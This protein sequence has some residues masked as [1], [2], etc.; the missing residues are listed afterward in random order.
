VQV[1]R[2]GHNTLAKVSI[3]AVVLLTG[4][5][6]WFLGALDRSPYKTEQRVIRDQPIAFSH[7]HHVGGLGLDCR[8]CHLSVETSKFAGLPPTSVCMNCHSQIWSN[9]SALAPVRDSYKNDKS[10]EWVRVHDL[11]DFAYF[12]HSIHVAKGVGCSTC[13]G[14]VDQMPLM[15]KEKTLQMEWCLECHRNP[16]RFVRPLKQVFQMDWTPPA[17]QDKQG[18]RLVQQHHIRSVTNCSGCHR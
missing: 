8:Y 5:S 10:I 16:E 12:D 18:K 14:R 7:Q 15:W 2:P 11:P 13:H 6:F 9:S 1:F 17:D 4:A 3:V